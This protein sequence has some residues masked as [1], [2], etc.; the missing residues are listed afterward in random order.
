MIVTVNSEFK[1]PTIYELELS[2]ALLKESAIAVKIIPSYIYPIWSPVLLNI[3][4]SNDEVGVV[5]EG[6]LK[7]GILNS[8]Y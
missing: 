3:D 1:S 6:F 4:N 5:E 7:L 2:V 8:K